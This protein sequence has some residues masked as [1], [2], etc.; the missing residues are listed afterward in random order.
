MTLSTQAR[1]PTRLGAIALL[2]TGIRPRPSFGTGR[3]YMGHR[4]LSASCASVAPRR[5]SDRSRFRRKSTRADLLRTTGPRSAHGMPKIGEFVPQD[6]DLEFLEVLRP[7]VQHDEF[8]QPARQRVAERQEHDAS[9]RAGR[10]S[11][12]TQALL[13]SCWCP[14]GGSEFLHP[15]RG[16]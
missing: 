9:Y 14:S 16:C 4:M 3:G 15:S 7:T 12:S 6:D 1:R 10:H 5:A 13:D 8:D 2:N 11:N